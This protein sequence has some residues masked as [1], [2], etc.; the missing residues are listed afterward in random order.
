MDVESTE[1]IAGFKVYDGIA[2]FEIWSFWGY[3]GLICK[4]IQIGKLHTFPDFKQF[5]DLKHDIHTL[6]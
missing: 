2:Y 1:G 6:S 5:P 3:E 4:S